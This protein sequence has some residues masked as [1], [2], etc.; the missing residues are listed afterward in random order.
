MMYSNAI[1]YKVKISEFSVFEKLWIFL[2]ILSFSFVSMYKSSFYGLGKIIN[3]EN[4][5]GCY[6]TLYE[7]L[8][9]SNMEI[10]AEQQR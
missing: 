2:R 10:S 8:K 7:I 4:D 9:A 5:L 1:G 6:L 3:L